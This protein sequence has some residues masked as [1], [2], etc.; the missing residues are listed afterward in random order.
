VGA[1]LATGEDPQDLGQERGQVYH[2]AS[3]LAE[4]I[5]F[6]L[7]KKLNPVLLRSI[8]AYNSVWADI[9]AQLGGLVKG[10]DDVRQYDSWMEKLA[11]LYGTCQAQLTGCLNYANADPVYGDKPAQLIRKAAATALAEETYVGAGGRQ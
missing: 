4:R 2:V 10:T 7:D 5:A 9:C 8:T 11:I 1:V 6:G 3:K